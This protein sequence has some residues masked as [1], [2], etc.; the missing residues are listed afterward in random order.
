MDRKKIAI[1]TGASSGIGREF[2]RLLDRKLKTIDEIWVVARREERLKEL[3]KEVKTPLVSF[4]WDLE[5]EDWIGL[6]EQV[7]KERQPLIK[8]L[9][10]GAGFG[11]IGDWDT[12]PLKQTVGMIDVNC[13]A[14]TAMTYLAIPYM[15][16]NSRIIQLASSAAFLPQPRFAV[17]AATKSY[18]LSFSRALNE[19]LKGRGIAVTAVCPGPVRTEFFDIAEE[20]GEVALYKKLVMADPV[21]VVRKAFRDSLQRRSLSV[22]GGIINIFWGI[23]KILPHSWILRFLE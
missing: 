9:V 5:Q 4:L 8:M 6:M 2:V 14:L 20:T 17:Y 23:C 13:R 22:Y 3:E 7:L 18:V 12:V 15:A 19:E 21:K 10:N 16:E 11:K 1:V